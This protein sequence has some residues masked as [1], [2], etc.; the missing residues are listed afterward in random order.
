MAVTGISVD[1]LWPT[2]SVPWDHASTGRSLTGTNTTL[3][4]WEGDDGVLTNHVE[5]GRR[6]GQADHS[7]TNPTRRAGTPRAWRARRAQGPRFRSRAP[8]SPV[9][10]LVQIPG[11]DPP[12]RLPPAWP[13]RFPGQRLGPTGK[14]HPLF[15]CVLVPFCVLEKNKASVS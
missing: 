4:L 11:D 15:Q 9:F 3:G 1:E 13:P 12:K 7:P 5:C 14:P 2:N 8:A 6:P 10:A